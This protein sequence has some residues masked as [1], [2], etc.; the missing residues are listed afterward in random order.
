MAPRKIV[1]APSDFSGFSEEAFR[2]LRGLKKNNDRD[3][4]LPRKAIFEKQLQEP[5]TQLLLVIEGEM[6]K[7]QVPL[8]TKQKGTLSRI[9]RDVRF[10]ANKDPYHTFL[11]GTLVR[12]GKKTAPGVLYVHVGEKEQLAA[13]G[14]WQP[15][16]PAL[17]NWR[18]RMQAEPNAFLN[19][20]K[21]LKNKGLVLDDMHR[22]QR[23]PRGFEAEDGT[24]IGEYLRYQS[25]V[26]VRPITKAETM[27]AELPHLVARF[28]LDAKPLLEYGWKVPIQPPTVFLD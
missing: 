12:N 28:A 2:F 24:P 5:L 21:Q 9:Y 16:R 17:T 15:E 18:L 20:I 19:M 8:L 22:L 13:V 23:M 6:K 11:S 3:W 1:A 27:S 10:S 7:N 26:I 14:F 4:F 25:F